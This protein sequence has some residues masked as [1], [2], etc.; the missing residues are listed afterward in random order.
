MT[1]SAASAINGDASQLE[2]ALTNQVE[3]SDQPA[4]EAAAYRIV[5]E[6]LTNG[7]CH[8]CARRCTVRLQ[9]TAI[10]L[11]IE[12]SGDGIG[13]PTDHPTCVG[14]LSMRER[15]AELGGT[16][17]ITSQPGSGTQVKAIL[18]VGLIIERDS[19]G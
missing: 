8:A 12:I 14:L 7:T 13:L 6:G 19:H 1:Y 3:A 17:Q 5:L 10:H 4:V 11:L 2:A 15:A 18:P 9:Q 16:C